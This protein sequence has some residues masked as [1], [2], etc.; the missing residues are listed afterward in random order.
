MNRVFWKLETYLEDPLCILLRFKG[1]R[2][3]WI[4][5]CIDWRDFYYPHRL[6]CLP[7]MAT[8]YDHFGFPRYHALLWPYHWAL[9]GQSLDSRAWRWNPLLGWTIYWWGARLVIQGGCWTNKVL[10]SCLQLQILL[11]WM[12]DGTHARHHRRMRA[13]TM[14][15]V[16]PAR[17]SCGRLITVILS[18]NA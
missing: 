13:L 12:Y 7:F 1:S 17:I 6:V 4:G 14:L 16:L 11:Y 3:T 2:S 5:S 18:S 9:P 15:L 10:I 8:H